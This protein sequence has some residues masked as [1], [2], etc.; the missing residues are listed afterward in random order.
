MLAGVGPG[1]E[2]ALGRLRSQ[3][4]DVL[5]LRYGGDL[6]IGEIG[7]LLGLTAANV[8]QIASR[9][10]RKLRRELEARADSAARG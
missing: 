10:R 5:A 3:E 8:Q 4:R 7:E 1:L 2:A 9:G 6:T